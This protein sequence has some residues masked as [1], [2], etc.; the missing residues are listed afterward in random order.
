MWYLLVEK[1]ALVDFF[2]SNTVDFYVIRGMDWL[3]SCYTSLGCCA[4]NVVF[5]LPGESSMEWEDGFIPQ[6]LRERL[7]DILQLGDWSSRIVSTI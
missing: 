5:R 6:L 2:D 3:H 4:R 7:H 1:G